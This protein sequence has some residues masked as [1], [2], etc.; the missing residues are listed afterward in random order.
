MIPTGTAIHQGQINNDSYQFTAFRRS[1]SSQEQIKDI[2]EEIERFGMSARQAILES[3]AK[4]DVRLLGIG[5]LHSAFQDRYPHY[6]FG[7]SLMANLKSHG[8]THLAIEMRKDSRLLAMLDRPTEEL[9]QYMIATGYLMGTGFIDML[10][11][12]RRVGLEI[13][14]VDIDGGLVARDRYM[15][16]TIDSILS[17]DQNNKVIFWVGSD[18]LRIK[19]DETEFPS[20]GQLLAEFGMRKAQAKRYGIFYVIM[21][22]TGG[23]LERRVTTNYF[24]K[25]LKEPTL[26]STKS[27]QLFRDLY[28]NTEDINLPFKKNHK[29]GRFDHLVILP[30]ELTYPGIYMPP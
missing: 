27:T 21:L 25:W 12:A 4:A 14:P 7:S 17:Q 16:E 13:L 30:G 11:E 15:A 19:S 28:L 23:N 6:D 29:V 24:G 26:V 10:K 9:S 1:V 18:H 20:A 22:N 8:A 3:F 5:E 2:Q